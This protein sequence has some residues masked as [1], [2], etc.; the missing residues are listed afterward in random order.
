[1]K[2]K[3][4]LNCFFGFHWWLL[5]LGHDEKVDMICGWCKKKEEWE[6][7]RWRAYYKSGG[8]VA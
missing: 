4:W 3:R 1:M 5:D 7:D 2:N 8:K 6:Y